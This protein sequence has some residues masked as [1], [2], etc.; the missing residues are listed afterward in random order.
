M[1]LYVYASDIGVNMFNSI[2]VNRKGI[3][4]AKNNFCC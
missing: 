4:I 2:L 3:D 1:Y